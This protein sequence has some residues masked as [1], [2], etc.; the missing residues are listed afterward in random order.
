MT[1]T[2]LTSKTVITVVAGMTVI[3]AFFLFWK[4]FPQN[5]QIE[6]VASPAP[7]ESSFEY[8]GWFA[9]DY[10]TPT[11]DLKRIRAYTNTGFAVVPLQAKILKGLG[12]KHI[13]YMTAF[14]DQAVLDQLETGMSTPIPVSYEVKLYAT[15]IPGYREKYFALYRTKLEELRR[16][17]EETGSLD[18]IDL[19]Y[20]ADEPA[21]QRNIY[22]DQEFL[23][24]TVVE[25]KRVFGDKKT[26][27]VFAQYPEPRDPRAVWAGPHFAPPPALDIVGTDPYMDFKKVSCDTESIRSWLYERNPATNIHW[28]KQFGKPIIVIGDAQI[29]DGKELDFCYSKAT[30]DI[31]KADKDVAG[32]IW[33]QYDKSYKEASDFGELSGA[34]NDPEF[35][36]MIENLGRK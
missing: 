5:S 7:R 35:V 4:S 1:Q 8:Y 27:M 2:G 26:T 31:L 29:R 17:L 11:E 9:V 22:P 19:F 3:V 10:S 28:A 30:F 24:R 25:F 18:A 15:G 23:D 33:Y 32:L 13:V 12:F 6:D 36:R 14:T 16:S 21:I 20:L 34:A